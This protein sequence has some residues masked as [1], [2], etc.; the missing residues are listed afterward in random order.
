MTRLD[1]AFQDILRA[2]STWDVDRVLTGLGTA[3]DWV[4]LGNNPANYG[5]ITMGS[6]PYN[7][8]TERITNA[9]DAMIELEVEL[10][11]ELRKCSTPRAAVEAIYGLREGNLRDTK[12]PE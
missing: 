10:K 5:L 4:P 9:I 2:K 8:I 11:P 12:D 7:G 3:V 6:D 1:N